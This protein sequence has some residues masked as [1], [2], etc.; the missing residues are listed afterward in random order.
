MAL[1]N[2]GIKTN[3]N[4]KK[5]YE[6]AQ[7]VSQ[8]ANIPIGEKA[9]LMGKDCFVHRSGMHQDGANKTKSLIK[10]QYLPYQPELIGRTDGEQLAFTSQS[11]KSALQTICGKMG[12]ILSNEQIQQLMPKAK[13]LAQTKGQLS[14]TDVSQLCLLNKSC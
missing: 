10:G 4:M 12:Y 7:F 9:P 5:F 14:A 1:H 8:M 11:G 6:T 13:S 2:A 3:L